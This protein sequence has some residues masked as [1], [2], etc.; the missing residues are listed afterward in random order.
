MIIPTS[1][2]EKK[3]G[4]TA[5]V[6]SS[7]FSGPQFFYCKTTILDMMIKFLPTPKF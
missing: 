6:P 4:S 1:F 7:T 3:S 2:E 5:N